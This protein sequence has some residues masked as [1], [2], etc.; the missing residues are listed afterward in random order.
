MSTVASM[1]IV[2]GIG[3]CTVLLLPFDIGAIMFLGGSKSSS[4]HMSILKVSECDIL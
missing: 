3:Y 2:T 1:K 4:V